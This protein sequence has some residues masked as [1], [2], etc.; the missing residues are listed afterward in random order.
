MQ[1]KLTLQS[2]GFGALAGVATTLLCLSLTGSTALA[3]ILFLISPV[4]LMVAG[5]GF[6]LTSALTGVAVAIITTLVFANPMIAALVTLTIALPACAAAYWLNLARP[7]EEIGG[8]KDHLA[9]Y[10]LADILF[11]MAMITG[12]AYVALG[13]L[14]GFGPELVAQLTEQLVAQLM[15]TNTE[16]VFTPE[17]QQSL[18][19]F[20][21]TA[22]PFTQPFLW[23]LTLVLSLYI[24][25][26]IAQRSGLIRRPREDWPTS[27]R[28]PRK[29]S[30]A[31]VVAVVA[32]LLPG[33][34]SLAASCF[35]GALAAGFVMAGFAMLHARTRGVTGR[36]AI[37]T[38]AYLSVAFIAFP[39]LLFFV[40]GVFGA[41]RNVPLTPVNPNTLTKND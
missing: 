8:P 18:Q 20:M 11:A 2:L 17:G 4:P 15:E 21:M 39:V 33:P 38:L 7:A 13:V 10:P 30:L 36:A 31:L 32:S 34:I 5:M 22:V 23:M 25:I 19:T 12:F 3:F 26:A 37:L 24:A 9:W 35:A 40:A 27:L 16:L 6:G 29:A 41:G 14:A 28:L 1:P